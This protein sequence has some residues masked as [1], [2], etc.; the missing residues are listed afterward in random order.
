MKASVVTRTSENEA[1]MPTPFLPPMARAGA[2]ETALT[3]LCASRSTS[4]PAV[5]PRAVGDAGVG[6]VVR[7]QDVHATADD[8]AARIRGATGEDEGRDDLVLVE[9]V[10][11][12]PRH[13]VVERL[14]ERGVVRARV[15]RAEGR[16]VAVNGA[17]RLHLSRLAE[18]GD[19][20]AE[21]ER[22]DGTDGGGRGVDV[23]RVLHVD[24]GVPAHEGVG[25]VGGPRVRERAAEALLARRSQGP[26]IGRRADLEGILGLG[27]DGQIAAD[28]EYGPGA[29]E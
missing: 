8:G 5:D 18:A 21:I 24:A 4:C 28:G 23:E 11:H 1:P 27:L 12:E 6:G 7:E 22:V 3:S 14:L 2:I 20:E 16:P 13:V 10:I 17:D 26:G 15:V 9:D 19:G 25:L 29:R